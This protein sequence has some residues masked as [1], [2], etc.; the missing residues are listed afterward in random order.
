MVKTKSWKS[1]NYN[2]VRVLEDRDQA[3]EKELK[4]LSDKE[5]EFE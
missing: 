1:A 3:Q 4:A 5:K 2:R